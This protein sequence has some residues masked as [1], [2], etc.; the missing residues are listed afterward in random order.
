LVN[1]RSAASYRLEL[2]RS[3]GAEGGIM[4]KHILIPTDGS[5]LSE[6]A[7]K[8]GVSLAK[9]VGAEVT[10][11]IATPRFHVASLDP[12]MVTDTEVQ[13][14]R[15]SEEQAAKA[16]GFVKEASEAA[17]VR[18][19]TDSAVDDA[20]SEAI[21]EAARRNDCDLIVMASHG[22]KAVSAML[23][24]SETTKVL[25]HSRIPVLVCR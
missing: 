19:T 21:I 3:T 18:C 6:K 22:R 16:L 10:G 12:T 20:P 11:F 15:H 2:R 1:T 13:F 4:Y 17:G 5:E 23:L 24:G 8:E 7:I 9:E 14:R 25:S